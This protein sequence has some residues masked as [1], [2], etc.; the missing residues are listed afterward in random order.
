MEGNVTYMGE[1]ESNGSFLDTR[2]RFP[3]IYDIYDTNDGDVVTFM[4][5]YRPEGSHMT[6]MTFQVE[7]W[8]PRGCSWCDLGNLNGFSLE[9]GEDGSLG[10]GGHMENHKHTP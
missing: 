2:A 5:Y 8:N 3:N 4:T 9:F 1:E 7:I 6:N 10:K